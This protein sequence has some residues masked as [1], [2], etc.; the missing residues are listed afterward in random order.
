MF[1]ANVR[2]QEESRVQIHE[3]DAPTMKLIIEYIYTA[4]VDIDSSNAQSIFIV[5]NMMQL[6]HLVELCADFMMSQLCGSNAVEIFNFATFYSCDKLHKAARQF[7]LENFREVSDTDGFSG[8][9]VTDL[10]SIL[11]EDN[12]GVELEEHVYSAVIKWV[13]FD[14]ENRCQHLKKLLKHVRLGLI[15]SDFI[16]VMKANS[17]LCNNSRIVRQLENVNFHEGLA[18]LSSQAAEKR[19]MKYNFFSTSVSPRLGMLKRT[20]LV[21]AGGANNSNERSLTC[22]DPSTNN[23]Y[24]GVKQHSSFDFKHKIDHH[25]VVASDNKL[26]FIGGVLYEEYHFEPTASALDAVFLYVEKDQCW[27]QRAHMLTPRCAFSAV[28]HRGRIYVMGGK[29]TYPRGG[30]LF[31]AECYDTD[32]DQWLPLAPMPLGLYHHASSVFQD[33]IFVFGGIE[34]DEEHVNTVFQYSISANSWTHV[35]T[36]MAHLRAE[37]SAVTYKDRIYLVGGANKTEN[38]TAVEIFNPK[39]R[40]WQIGADFPEDRKAMSAV[41]IGDC[42]YVCGGEK[43]IGARGNRRSRMVESRDLYKYDLV[44]NDWSRQVKLVQYANIQTCTACVLNT[45]FLNESDFISSN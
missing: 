14:K 39:S 2:E 11:S 33:S 42:V 22:F 41:L 15:Q 5:A 19:D 36:M 25:R 40:R 27:M 10:E 23:N 32:S 17:L 13:E 45:K 3:V 44:T 38:V 12:L 18:S 7:I 34:E 43:Y 1:T 30:P 37:F 26:Y 6:A 29:T 9:N 24:Y 4:S 21:F 8:F 28:S 35:E 16:S 20:M 31:T